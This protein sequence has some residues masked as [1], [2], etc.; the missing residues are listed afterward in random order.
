[1]GDPLTRLSSY[2]GVS[3]LMEQISN[4]LDYKGSVVLSFRELTRELYD[5][6]RFFHVKS[7]GHRYLHV[8]LNMITIK[9]SYT[10]FFTNAKSITGHRKSALAPSFV[11]RQTMSRGYFVSTELKY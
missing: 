3:D 1:M 7:D 6:D 4:K 8:S 2:D 5:T 9:L 10:I 11:C